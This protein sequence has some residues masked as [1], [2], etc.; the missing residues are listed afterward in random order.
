MLHIQKN[1]KFDVS[2]AMEQIM[3]K[4]ISMLEKIKLFNM[5]AG[6]CYQEGDLQAAFD[7]LS[8]AL[9]IDAYNADILKN[10]AYVCLS[11]GEK[12]Q[13]MEYASRLPMV[14]FALL[15]AIRHGC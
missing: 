8:A 4:N 13:A 11:A 3:E 1:D 6:A 12:E 10:M 7:L 15:Y 2:A 14:D 5:F 9:E